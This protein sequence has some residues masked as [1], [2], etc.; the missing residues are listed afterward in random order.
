MRTRV[1]QA[2]S[3]RE[4][5]CRRRVPRSARCR[6]RGGMPRS[7]SW[8]ARYGTARSDRPCTGGRASGRRSRRPGRTQW[9]STRP[10]AS[11]HATIAS[12]G[13]KCTIKENA[14]SEYLRLVP[15][16]WYF[17]VADKSAIVDVEIHMDDPPP[18]PSSGPS[19]R[20]VAVSVTGEP[21]TV[22]ARETRR[23]AR[24]LP[25]VRRRARLDLVTN[26]GRRIHSTQA[27]RL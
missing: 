19:T 14:T 1:S 7:D 15:D 27:F 10:S 21:E 12:S 16:C 24:R 17:R 26:D 13:R 2:E 5:G 18:S 3:A 25:A 8:T 20:T 22:K 23:R 4:L 11:A 6:R 9:S